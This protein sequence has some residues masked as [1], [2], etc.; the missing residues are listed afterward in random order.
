MPVENE[1]IKQPEINKVHPNIQILWAIQHI[2]TKKIGDIQLRLLCSSLNLNIP[3]KTRRAPLKMREYLLKQVLQKPIVAEKIA[4]KISEQLFQISKNPEP[5]SLLELDSPEKAFLIALLWGKAHELKDERFK[6]VWQCW[7]QETKEWRESL[8]EIGYSEQVEKIKDKFVAAEIL[9]EAA[10]LYNKIERSREEILK[11]TIEKYEVELSELQ[12]ENK[13]LRA[14][15]KFL[16]N[17][18]YVLLKNKKAKEELLLGRKLLVIADP[19]HIEGYR[20]LI[21]SY[22]AHFTFANAHDVNGV[23]KVIN[24][25][26]DAIL[27]FTANASHVVSDQVKKQ[28]DAPV[29][30]VNRAGLGEMERVLQAEALPS[31]IGGDLEV[32]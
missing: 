21:T 27:F 31:L 8:S 30:Y 7:Q 14:K 15:N 19:S 12:L 4:C 25:K 29:Y 3:P 22:G 6:E 11:L 18:L 5:E 23:K 9:D 17:L 13:L 1:N 28:K 32:Y 26:Y 20:K 2:L 24:A 10:E 16:E